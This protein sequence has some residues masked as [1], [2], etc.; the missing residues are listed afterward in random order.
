MFFGQSTD[1]D[2][3][4]NSNFTTINMQWQPN[5]ALLSGMPAGQQWGRWYNTSTPSLKFLSQAEM[6][7]VDNLVNLQY[8]DESANISDPSQ[9]NE[10][11]ATFESWRSLYPNVL[12]HTN[13]YAN[14]FST[15][16]L[17]N[18][19]QVAQ[20]DVM[21]FDNYPG[22]SFLTSSRNTWYTT[23]QT[24]RTLG[25]AGN[26]GTGQEPIPYAQYLDLY[27]T[28]YSKP[29]PSES[30][31]RLQQFASWAFGYTAV[32]A[33]V[34]NDP[35][36]AGVVPVMFSSAGDT[37]PTPVFNFVAETNRQSR[38]LG[39]ALVRLLSTDIRMI[40]GSGRSISGTGVAAWAANANGGDNYITAIVPTVSQG[41][42]NDASYDDILVG[43]FE[44]LLADNSDYLFADG[45]HFMIVNGAPYGTSSASSQWYHL[46]FDFGSSGFNALER[47]SR[48]TGLVE[49]ITL[50][51]LTGSQYSLD[52]NLPGGTGDLF[53]FTSLAGLPGDYNANGCVD[54]ADYVLWR[55]GGPLMNEIDTPG[56]VNGADYTEWRARF[57]NPGGSGAA[58][59]LVSQSA[60]PEPA[61]WATLLLGILAIPARRRATV[62]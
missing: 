37:S 54:A 49:P 43:Y 28:N 2:L 17:Q 44:P 7:Y 24:Y 16:D 55:K 41:G 59:A 45:T 10:M 61:T 56:T 20:P 1:V 48:N 52:L 35:L 46:T 32:S 57:G 40:A 62:S 47:L 13:F 31:V 34:Y 12:A 21:M 3:W 29:M 60:V 18:F 53:R 42:A 25:L 51:H 9:L 22:F 36:F 58:G 30:F 50:T 14:Q 4:L 38:N 15:A 5:P 39:P 26:D 33:F 8:G 19:M 11:S 6:N 23:M 27:R